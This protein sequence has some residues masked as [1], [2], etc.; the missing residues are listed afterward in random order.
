MEIAFQNPFMLVFILFIPILIILHYYFFE[1]NK[2]KAMK[3]ANFK[4]MKHVTGTNLIT[5]NNT[6]LIVR[7]IVLVLFILSAAGPEIWYEGDVSIT[8]YVI[9]ID[10]SASMTS[11]DVSPDRLTI[12]KQAALN[13]VDRLESDTNV[14]VLSFA[15]TTFVK[16]AP[17]NQLSTVKN[18]INRIGIE[19]AG[20]TDIGTALIT[21][22]NLLSPV[23]KSKAIIL[24]TDGSDTSGVFID[25]SVETSLEYITANHIIVHTIGIGSGLGETGYLEGSGLK[26]AYD[27]NT[28]NM[29]STRTGGKFF[30]VKSSSEIDSAFR[31]IDQEKEKGKIPFRITPFLYALSMIMLIFE[32]GVLNTKFRSIP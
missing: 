27:K 32:W 9:A 7:I 31:Q 29:I 13:F 4:A 20:G 26:A 23:E 3:F 11:D 10:A 5:K 30:E 8:D 19:L 22:T 17:T 14:G 21:G 28:L 25:E 1:H 24:I 12:A 6:Q 2:K 18:S 16:N 15:G